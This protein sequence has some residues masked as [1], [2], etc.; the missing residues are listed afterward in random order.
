MCTSGSGGTVTLDIPS[1]Q[2]AKQEI[3]PRDRPGHFR[4]DTPITHEQARHA[5]L[6]LIHS[7]FGIA[8]HARMTIPVQADDDDVLI[9]D[10]IEQQ[11]LKDLD[12]PK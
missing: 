8:P 4:R 7:H 10:Y 6:R 11:V 9:I 5:A 2:T 12:L 3:P 1:K